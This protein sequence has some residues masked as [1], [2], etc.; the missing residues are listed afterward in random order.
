M[1]LALRIC[2]RYPKL[3]PIYLKI[4]PTQD[5]HRIVRAGDIFDPKDL[6]LFAISDWSLRQG[7]AFTKAKS[8]ATS[9]NLVCALRMIF[10]MYYKLFY[11]FSLIFSYVHTFLELYIFRVHALVCVYDG[12]YFIY[13]FNIAYYM[14]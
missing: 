12:A 11:L 1:T 7:V 10:C 8:N 6:L 3:I 13:Y 14:M 9:H 4:V 5:D 2:Y